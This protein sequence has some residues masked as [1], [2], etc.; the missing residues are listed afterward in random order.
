MQASPRC[1]VRTR[2]GSPCRPP[3]VKGHRRCR[4]HGGAAGSGR[5]R[6]N[7]NALKN[8]LYCRELVELRRRLRELAAETREVLEQ[9]S[10]SAKTRV[11]LP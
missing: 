5:Q 8:G 10:P 2:S 9:V 7:R 6:G 4:M 1:G 11:R 3:A